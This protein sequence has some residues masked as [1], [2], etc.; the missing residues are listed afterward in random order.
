MTTGEALASGL[1]LIIISD[2]MHILGELTPCGGLITRP[3]DEVPEDEQWRSS[4]P[5]PAVAYFDGLCE[6]IKSLRLIPLTNDTNNPY[7]E[8]WE[9]VNEK[10]FPNHYLLPW[11]KV[12]YKSCIH[13]PI[14]KKTR[15]PKP[16]TT[17][18]TGP[19]CATFN[20][21]SVEGS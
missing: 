17:N 14:T 10:E 20:V 1:R 3:P 21:P 19:T 13:D 8:M 4:R 6:D 15:R 18:A 2:L 5:V 12:T 7:W 16:S 9:D 11:I